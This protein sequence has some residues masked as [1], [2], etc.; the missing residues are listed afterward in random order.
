MNNALIFGTFDGVHLGHRS[1]IE[2]VKGHNIIA[3]TF[4]V[5]P[6]SV[7]KKKEN[8]LMLYEKRVDALKSAGVNEVLSLDFE[9][10]RDISHTDFIKSMFEKFKPVKIACGFNF[11][12][13]KGALGDVEY[14]SEVCK[15]NGIDFCCSEDVKMYGN[16]VSSSYIRSL[17]ENGLV[18][19]ANTLMSADFGFK[20]EVIKGDA[21]G[22]TLGFPTAN[23]MYPKELVKAK[24]GVYESRT[25][26]G[27]KV[28]KSVT[29][30]GIRPTFKTECITAETFV[31][32]YKGDLYGTYPELRLKSFI[33]EEKKFSDIDRLKAAIADDISKVGKVK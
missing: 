30:V 26:I 7:T 29:N 14:L 1:V 27:N 18:N 5:P 31:F 11:R 32:G 22:R 8:L 6:K 16:T 23:Q 21:R 9:S 19:K 25:V 2:S 20:G 28:Y 17:I 15:E 10:V 3:V 13:G 4:K 24:F 33:R 12:F